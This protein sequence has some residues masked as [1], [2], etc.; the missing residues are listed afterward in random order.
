V[1]A[2]PLRKQ[3][4]GLLRESIL[5]FQYQPGQRLVERELCDRFGVS[6]TVIREALRH[7]EADGLVDL[8]PNHGPVVSTIST[9]DARAL[10]DIRE[11]VESMAARYFAERATARQKKRLETALKRVEHAY[12]D[13]RLIEELRA[14]DSFYEV[15]FEGCGNAVIVST[16]RTLHNRAQ[17]LRAFSLQ[18]PGRST[19][20]VGE[21]REMVRAIDAGDVAA[22]HA[23]AAEHVRKA[24]AVVLKSLEVVQ[25]ADDAASRPPA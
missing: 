15:V 16:L 14:K 24:A 5:S 10:F 12:R 3:V 17:M 19:E 25:A 4:I 6:R 2:A 11:T 20:A 21:L 7:L 23:A 9:D 13:G 8:L 18:A 1:V 22:A